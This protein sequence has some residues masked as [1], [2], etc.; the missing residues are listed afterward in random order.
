MF[1]SAAASESGHR[2]A[3]APLVKS[4]R[5]EPPHTRCVGNLH[6]TSKIGPVD[7]SRRRPPKR[8]LDYCRVSTIRTGVSAWKLLG[9]VGNAPLTSTRRCVATDD[10][11]H[12]VPVALTGA[13]T[14]FATV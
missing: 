10:T 14:A 3:S 4:S 12:T 1:P 2:R 9:D 11:K 13:N 5:A 8:P 6:S 7:A